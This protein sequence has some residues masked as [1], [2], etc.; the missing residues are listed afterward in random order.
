MI[1][2]KFWEEDFYWVS[3]ADDK[4]SKVG[5]IR[6]RDLKASE[7]ILLEDGNCLKDHILSA[8]KIS[9]SSQHSFRASTLTTVIQLVKGGM[10]TTVIPEMA[11]SQLLNSDPELTRGSH[12]NEKGHTGKSR[13]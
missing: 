3:K 2:F 6:A 10:G 11:I 1:A 12:L 7:L 4:R 8:C 13:L 9:E 5:K